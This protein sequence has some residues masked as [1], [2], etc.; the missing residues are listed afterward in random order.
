MSETKKQFCVVCKILL[1]TGVMAKVT[2]Q[3]AYEF[4]DG[5]RCP[6]CATIYVNEKRGGKTVENTNKEPESKGNFGFDGI[7]TKVDF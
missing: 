3:E 1:K 7:S 5:I 4:Q 6:T 2:K